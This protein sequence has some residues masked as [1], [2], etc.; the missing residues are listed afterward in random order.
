M[1]FSTLLFS[2]QATARPLHPGL[3]KCEPEF[4]VAWW[5]P[6]GTF[7]SRQSAVSPARNYSCLSDS[8][9]SITPEDFSLNYFVSP[10]TFNFLVIHVYG[11]SQDKYYASVTY[12]S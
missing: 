8:M 6:R 7:E 1:I 9:S 4:R 12:L 3:R 5:S 2:E 10:A 11:L